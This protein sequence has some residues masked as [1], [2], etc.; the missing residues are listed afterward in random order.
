MQLL[1]AGFFEYEFDESLKDELLL[2][3]RSIFREARNLGNPSTVE[4]R[5]ESLEK[6]VAA[7]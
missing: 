7:Y 2:S 1:R 6:L 4:E 5:K 3:R